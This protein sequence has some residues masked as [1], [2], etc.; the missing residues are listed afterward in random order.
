MERRTF[1]ALG[2][3]SAAIGVTGCTRGPAEPGPASAPP[4]PNAPADPDA[5]L[6]DDVAA[7]EVALIAS[8]RLAIRENP[9]T[10][11]GP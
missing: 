8:Y 11:G 10:R 5:R 3:A 6:R 4:A 2:I 1:L 9:G 7:S